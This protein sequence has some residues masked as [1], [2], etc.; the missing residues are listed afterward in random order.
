MVEVYFKSILISI[1]FA[2]IGCWLAFCW[3]WEMY[4][5]FGGPII[6]LILVWIYIYIY[7]HIDSTKNRIRLFLLNPVLYFFIFELIMIY[8]FSITEIHPGNI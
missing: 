7:K 2:A 1:P 5:L 6:G 3:D 8:L 4:G